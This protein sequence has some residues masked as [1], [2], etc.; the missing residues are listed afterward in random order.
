MKRYQ[1]D[2]LISQYADRLA[3]KGEYKGKTISAVFVAP[4][5]WR[6]LQELLFN[7]ANDL[8]SEKILRQYEEFDVVVVFDYQEYLEDQTLDAE[9]LVLLLPE[10]LE[11]Q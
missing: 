10:I 2:E 7:L 1:C 9:S 8:S 3:D 11:E 4:L 5:P 6:D